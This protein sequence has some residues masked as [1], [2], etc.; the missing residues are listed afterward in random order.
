M[1][2]NHKLGIGVMLHTVLQHNFII[3]NEIKARKKIFDTLK[4]TKNRVQYFRRTFDA[5]TAATSATRSVKFRRLGKYVWENI[6]G[7]YFW[8]NIF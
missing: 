7:T 5:L 6:L 8:E 1:Y 3:L 2:I 4:K